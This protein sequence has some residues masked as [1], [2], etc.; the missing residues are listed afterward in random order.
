VILIG[1][2]P[3]GGPYYI[4]NL[5]AV[6]GFESQDRNW[7]SKL[8]IMRVD[9]LLILGGMVVPLDL[10]DVGNVGASAPRRAFGVQRNFLT[11]MR[12]FGASGGHLLYRSSLR[13][14]VSEA[15]GSWQLTWVHE[16]HD[17]RLVLKELA[18]LDRS[19]LRSP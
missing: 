19:G 11:S 10:L 4:G 6:G 1:T 12:L 2:L 7:L 15:M 18:N 17:E 5:G 3:E 16:A 9:K 14:L 13:Y 8:D